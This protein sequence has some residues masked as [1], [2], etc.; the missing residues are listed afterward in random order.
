MLVDVCNIP[1]EVLCENLPFL[2]RFNVG[3]DTKKKE[4][5]AK[6]NDDSEQMLSHASMTTWSLVYHHIL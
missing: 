4:E 3:G 5:S 6:D 2:N 1:V